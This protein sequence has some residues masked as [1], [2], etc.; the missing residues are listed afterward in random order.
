MIPGNWKDPIFVGLNN[1]DLSLKLDPMRFGSKSPVEE[2]VQSIRTIFKIDLIWLYHLR[3]ATQV[4]LVVQLCKRS[5]GPVTL[6][7]V[8][9][10][11]NVSGDNSTGFSNFR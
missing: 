10:L 1:S 2:V 3:S 8:K 5:H 9:G 6:S 7:E 11:G 4:V